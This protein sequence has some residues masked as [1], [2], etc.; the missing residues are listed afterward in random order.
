MPLQSSPSAG[1]IDETTRRAAADMVV[2]E[3]A[4]RQQENSP[5]RLQMQLNLEFLLGNQHVRMNP[6]VGRIEPFQKTYWYRERMVFNQIRPIYL[7]RCSRLAQMKPVAKVRPGSSEQRDL[8]TAR[9]SSRILK[10]NWFDDQNPKKLA[11][12]VAWTELQGTGFLGPRWDP[13]LGKFMGQAMM[14]TSDPANPMQ[15]VDVQEGDVTTDVIPAEHVLPDSPWRGDVNDCGSIIIAKIRTVDEVWDQWEITV[16]EE[17]ITG[18]QLEPLQDTGGLMEREPTYIGQAVPLKNSVTEKHYMERPSK[19][20]PEGR[21]IIVVADKCVFYDEK[22]PFRVGK[23]ETPAIPLLRVVAEHRPGCFWGI[24]VIDRLI[25][26]QRRYNAIR[27]ARAEY[28]KRVA[29]GQWTKPIGACDDSVLQQGPGGIIGYVPFAGMKPE[30]VH[31][32]SLP[33]EFSQEEASCMQEFTVI[34]GVSELSR[35]SEAPPGV[36]AGVSLSIAQEQD[37]TRMSITAGFFE[38][39]TIELAKMKLRLYKQFVKMPRLLRD[40]G[41]DD[42]AEIVGWTEADIRSDDV[43]LEAGSGLSD[44]PAQRVQKIYDM[45][46]NPAGLFTNDE[47]KIPKTTKAKLLEML[48]MGNWED[49]A[50]DEER[51]H[52]QKIAREN[53]YLKQGLQPEV[54]PYDDHEGHIQGHYYPCLSAEYEMLKKTPQGQQMFVRIDTHV[55]G[56]TVFLQSQMQQ[57]AALQSPGM[58]QGQVPPEGQGPPGGMPGAV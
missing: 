54:L 51:A 15:V 32:P 57:M 18:T 20:F 4:R 25:P 16:K 37:A 8:Y 21:Y 34:S 19:R 9:V 1:K 3:F 6:Y 14:P 43:I 35:F 30:P 22:L 11:E 7:T 23:D 39:A 42:I 41:P 27:N 53:L 58:P 29:I 33:P 46:E 26:V 52:R 5:W 12:L 31:W 28:L 24:S 36:K 55:Q 13:K 10:Q 38:S 45:I 49:A 56:H 50:P 48:D 40:I 47:G 2:K 44:T 17:R